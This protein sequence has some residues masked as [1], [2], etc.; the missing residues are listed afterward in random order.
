MTGSKSARTGPLSGLVVAD[1]SRVL[2]GPYA[3]MLLADLGAEVIK[4][5]SPSG[6]DTRT[7]S[8]PVRDGVST[9]YLAVN[10]NKRS[11]VLDLKDPDDLATAQEL[12]ARADVVIE[13]FKPGGLRRFGLDHDSV[14]AHNADV[15]YASISGFGTGA[16]ASLPGYDL[17]VQAMS[18]LMSLTGDP[19]GRP[20]RAGIS[21]F[22]VMTGMHAAIGILSALHHRARTGQGQ[23]IEVDLLSSA[24]STLVNH[25]SAYVAGGTVP[26]RMGNA[27]PSLFPY[28]PLPTADRDLI[29]IAGNDGQFRRLCAVLGLEE[30]VD[31]PRFL[32]NED[33]TANREQ[34]RPHLVR[35]LK[36]RGADEWFELLTAAGLPA[37]PINTV[38]DGVELAERLGLDPVVR[39][40]E[41]GDM[42]PSVRNPITFSTTPASYLL[43]P[44]RL[45]QHTEQIRAW[46]AARPSPAGPDESTG[47]TG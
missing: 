13:N 19:E 28:E 6:D 25:T 15:V 22:D 37:G 45:G 7:W 11:I 21:V 38:K 43:A 14:R 23:H 17:L 30:L 26:L 39:V 40:G 16:G 31:D 12:A 35:A 20:Y 42:V 3:T 46:L 24:L 36:Q 27:H 29:V 8:P 47:P 18:G 41:G 4:V 5:E 44:P 1:F 10:R 33:R 32:H 2:A 34:L 9:Y